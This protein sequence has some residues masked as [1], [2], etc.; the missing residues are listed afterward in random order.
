MVEAALVVQLRIESGALQQ[1][2]DGLRQRGITGRG[3]CD[4]VGLRR[5][6]VIIV[7]QRRLRGAGEGGLRRFPVRADQQNRGR[8]T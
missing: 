7:K 4:R 6:A 5:K 3:V 8:F 2:L 1:L